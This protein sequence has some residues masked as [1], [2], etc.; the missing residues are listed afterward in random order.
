M[1]QRHG[2]I[3]ARSVARAQRRFGGIGDRGVSMIWRRMTSQA[4]QRSAQRVSTSALGLRQ[5][6]TA[7]A[8]S[9]YSH[10]RAP[11]P[12]LLRRAPLAAA[13][14]HGGG[15]V[16]A[17]RRRLRRRALMTQR[18]PIA[19]QCATARRITTAQLRVITALTRRWSVQARSETTW[20]LF[21]PSLAMRTRRPSRRG[22]APGAWRCGC[23]ARRRVARGRGG[24]DTARVRVSR[25]RLTQRALVSCVM[26]P[27]RAPPARTRCVCMRRRC[28]CRA[29]RTATPAVAWV[30]AGAA[31]AAARAR[32]SRRAR[33]SRAAR[34]RARLGAPPRDGAALPLHSPLRPPPRGRA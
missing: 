14:R 1:Q 30:R 23:R 16:A 7:V 24:R 20:R 25:A 8:S 5:V 28:S 6:T 21:W 15:A 22:C 26:P 4:S 33:T 32:H 11:A 29:A 34:A 10:S 13:A 2:G 19:A 17:A 31:A 18:T 3:V 27:R 12:R 9:R